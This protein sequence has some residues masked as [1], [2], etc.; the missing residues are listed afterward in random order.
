MEAGGNELPVL[1]GQLGPLNGQRWQIGQLLM[2]GRDPGC[3]IVIIDRQISRYHARITPTPE[4]ILL[5]DLGSKNG[6]YVNG[7][8]LG[9]PCYL[10]DGDQVEISKDK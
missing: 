2:I 5:E 1:I 3:N 9:E 4:G 7:D 8:L 6:T 10:K